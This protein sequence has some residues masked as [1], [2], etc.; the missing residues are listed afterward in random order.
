MARLPLPALA[1]GPADARG[2]FG[3]IRL[4]L[5]ALVETGHIDRATAARLTGLPRDAT[6]N[7]TLVSLL[8]ILGA[9]AVA[10][11]VLL[12][13]PTATTGLVLATAALAGGFVIRRLRL[14]HLDVLAL[15][16]AIAG[17]LGL[18]GWF[19]MEFGERVAPLAVY[20]F[21]TGTIL[22]VALLFR[23]LF[24]SALVPLGVAAMLGSST[25]YWTGAYAVIVREPTLVALVF[26]PLTA[27]LFLIVPWLRERLAETY[28]T[29]AEVAGRMSFVV[30]NMGLWVGSI[31]GDRIGESFGDRPSRVT[32][33]AYSAYRE[34]LDAWRESLV[35]IPEGVFTLGWAGVAL[36]ALYLGHRTDR[37][38]LR[39]GGATFLAINGYTQFFETF[40]DEPWALVFAGTSL[41]AIAVALVRFR[42]APAAKA[43]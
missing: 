32:S 13:K 4:D 14:A 5:D 1:G 11:G 18:S 35:H 19:A 33:E 25:A 3:R 17:A 2:P 6:A 42:F 8:Y 9:L 43:T 10:A 12:L 15:G 26:V 31:W 39:D 40:Q 27:M 22:A 29:M 20:A 16:L 34:R 24:L 41:V 23:S 7:H 38:F 28:G 30:L 37:R 36:A 21:G